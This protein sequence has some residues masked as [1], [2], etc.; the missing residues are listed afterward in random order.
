MAHVAL[1]AAGL[2]LFDLTQYLLLAQLELHLVQLSLQ[3]AQ[4]GFILELASTSLGPHPQRTLEPA[5]QPDLSSLSHLP[6][7]LIGRFTLC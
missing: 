6:S 3:P 2:P 4:F 5:V 1:R 7:S